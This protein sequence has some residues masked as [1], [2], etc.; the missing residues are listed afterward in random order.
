[1]ISFQ[2]L[3]N[4]T[5]LRLKSSAIVEVLDNP[6]DGLWLVATAVTAPDG[7]PADGAEIML[8]VNDVEAVVS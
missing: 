2:D 7:T 4:G 5:R 3:K 8:D 6:R 1:M